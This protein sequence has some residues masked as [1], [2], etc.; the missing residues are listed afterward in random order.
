MSWAREMAAAISESRE[1]RNAARERKEARIL[2]L[3]ADGMRPGEIS[4]SMGV[5]PHIVTKVLR[6][7]GLAN[8][9]RER[10]SLRKRY[11]KPRAKP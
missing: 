7:A 8:N 5:G 1:L 6:E 11:D 10:I 3:H 9:P 4:A 2:K